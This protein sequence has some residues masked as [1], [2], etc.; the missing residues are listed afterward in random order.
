MYLFYEQTDGGCSYRVIVSY[1]FSVVV[2]RISHL[3][4]GLWLQN[5]KS[6]ELGVA[7]RQLV[8]SSSDTSRGFLQAELSREAEGRR[9]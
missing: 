2:L 8:F 9:C 7:G 1:C 4:I 3:G 5:V 6:G